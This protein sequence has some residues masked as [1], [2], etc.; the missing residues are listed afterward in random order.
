VAPVMKFLVAQGQEGVSVGSRNIT[1]EIRNLTV[2]GFGYLESAAGG[3]AVY[4]AGVQKA[5]FQHVHF[6]AN[7]GRSGGAVLIR[8]SADVMLQSCTFS[9]MTLPCSL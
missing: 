1:L 9:G 2:Q 4:L 8:D 3:G 6:V 5:L 7:I